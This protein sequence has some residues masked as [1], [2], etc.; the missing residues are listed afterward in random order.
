M[1]ITVI[2]GFPCVAE[3]VFGTRIQVVLPIWN[4]FDP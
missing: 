4:A 3:A 1:L 2:G